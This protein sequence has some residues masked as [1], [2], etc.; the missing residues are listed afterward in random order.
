[1]LESNHWNRFLD[2]KSLKTQHLDGLYSREA[3]E[4]F[5]LHKKI[6]KSGD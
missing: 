4:N 1:M 2:F 6:A 3:S 5:L